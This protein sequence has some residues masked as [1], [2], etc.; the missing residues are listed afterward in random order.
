[1]TLIIMLAALCA[2][3]LFIYLGFMLFDGG[4]ANE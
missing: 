4:T 3:G 1:M 2:L